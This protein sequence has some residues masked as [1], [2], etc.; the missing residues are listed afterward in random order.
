MDLI[1]PPERFWTETCNFPWVSF[2]FEISNLRPSYLNSLK[3]GGLWII[4]NVKKI[5]RWW[6]QLE[7]ELWIF[8]HARTSKYRVFARKIPIKS[9]KFDLGSRRFF[10]HWNFHQD[11]EIY[12]DLG[13]VAWNSRSRT[14]NTSRWSVKI[15][16]YLTCW[17]EF[18]SIFG[19]RNR[20]S[21]RKTYSL[22]IFPYSQSILAQLQ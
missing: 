18:L 4:S 3:P 21:V 8:G 2:G 10:L 20:I 5:G 17:E 7:T 22:S 19:I 13:G 6:N 15:L 1:T 16:I 11:D 9:W 12:R 14:Q